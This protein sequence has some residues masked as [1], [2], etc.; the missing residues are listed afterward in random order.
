VRSATDRLGFLASSGLVVVGVTYAG[1]VGLGIAEAGLSDPIVDPILAVMETITLVAA[2]LIVV[3]MSAVYGYASEDRKTLGLIA[4]SFAV[5]M[6]GLTSGVH[7]IALTAGRQGG[8]NALE[9][10]SA[11]YAAELLA[12]DVFLGLCLLFAAPV[13][14]GSGLHSV[15]RWTV[16]ATGALCVIGAIGP[17]VG[18][19][20]LQRIG[21][22][23][24]GVGLP[25]ACLIVALVFRRD[26]RSEAVER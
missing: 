1:V 20:A 11:L 17:I 5:V 15:A 25:I 13:F 22:V 9:W 23:G 19:M 18:D 26:G 14:A 10:P 16:A 7:F 24:Y 4:L 12:W 3:L 2:L 21:I 6:A 8:F